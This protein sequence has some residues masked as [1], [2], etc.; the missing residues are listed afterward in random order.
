MRKPLPDISAT[1]KR[2][3]IRPADPDR[4]SALAG[5]LHLS[6]IAGQLLLNRGVRDIGRA[7]AFLEPSLNDLHDP[8]LLP[9]AERAARRLGEAVQKRERIVIYGDYDVDGITAT[10][11]MLKCLRL[12]GADVRFYLPDRLEEGYGLNEEAVRRIAADGAHLLLTVDCGVTSLREISLARD[13]GMEVIVTDHHAPTA[14]SRRLPEVAY[15]VVSP[16]RHDSAYPFPGLAGVGVAFKVA[17]ALGKNLNGGGQCSAMFRD[18]LLDAVAL[19]GLGTIA[20]VV[21]LL[22]ENRALARYGLS[23]LQCSEDPGIR[24]LCRTARVDQAPL[25]AFDV[26]FKLGPRL[27]AAGRLG[28]AHRAVELLTTRD[29]ARAREIA[30]SLSAEN[31]RRQRIQ[32][33][34]LEAARRAVLDGPP[35]EQQAA[36]V[37]A[38]AE[39]HAG[40]VGVVAA[41][42]TDEF[43]RPSLCLVLE[44]EEAH[45]S[46]RSVEGVNLVQVLAE[47]DDLLTR[48]GGHARAA[49][50]RL[51]TRELEPFTERFLQVVAARRAPEEMVP[52]LTLDGDVPLDRLN[53]NLLREIE[54]LE[55]FGEGNPPPLFRAEGLSVGRVRRLGTRGQ[56]LSFWVRQGDV[57]ARAIAFGMG[58]VA[59]SLE[60][61]GVC[62]VAY[63]P[64]IN[65]YRGGREIELRVRDIAL[66]PPGG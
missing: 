40:V 36:L 13:L 53:G 29:E 22:D 64:Q 61:A 20:D 15:A 46:G 65:T 47:C 30:A 6:P 3:R 2:W 45:G 57:A 7:R 25:S 4:A 9:D 58:A 24:A 43:H 66:P 41:R 16:Q 51:P 50:L 60:A 17:W 42:L 44:G 37:T 11:L 52:V 19:V 10:A 38:S 12:L 54:R 63:R 59:D 23:A 56:H 39:W 18:F 49:G 31:T 48:Y 5:G 62:S 21:P 8:S 34:M 14:Q 26:A 33:R 35:I 27:N 1:G 32:E 55:P 28:T